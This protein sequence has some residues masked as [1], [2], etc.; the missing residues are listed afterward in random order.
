M[1][2][3]WPLP[4]SRAPTQQPSGAPPEPHCRSLP[5][6]APRNGVLFGLSGGVWACFTELVGPLLPSFSQCIP[7]TLSTL[8]LKIIPHRA[9][10]FL[11]SPLVP[12]AG[13]HSGPFLATALRQRTIPSR[14]ALCGADPGCRHT[15]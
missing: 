8:V 7:S 6:T 11:P 1:S 13:T 4:V 5:H 10:M 14:R 2:Q 12:G 15:A 9:E 3:R